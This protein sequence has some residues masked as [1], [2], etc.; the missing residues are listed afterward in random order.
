MQ[1]N[2]LLKQI[3]LK[4]KEKEKEKDDIITLY[5]DSNKLNIKKISN[6]GFYVAILFS[7]CFF[8]TNLF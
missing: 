7:Y 4:E 8:S 5:I 6:I 1:K 2:E 3:K